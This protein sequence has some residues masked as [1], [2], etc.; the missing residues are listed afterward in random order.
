M[1]RLF[2]LLSVPAF[3]IILSVPALAA[4][5]EDGYAFLAPGE[6]LTATTPLSDV[7]RPA[8]KVADAQGNEVLV[9]AKYAAGVRVFG[10]RTVVVFPRGAKPFAVQA[11][12]QS[13]IAE[14]S[15]A[16]AAKAALSIEDAQ[17]VA[18]RDVRQRGGA[19]ASVPEA[20]LSEPET[21]MYRDA[22]GGLRLCHHLTVPVMEGAVPT[23]RDY[24]IDAQS[25]AVVDAFSQL[26]DIQQRG[27]TATTGTGIGLMSDAVKEFPIAAHEGQYR[28]FDSGR[29]IAISNA[30]L[31][32]YSL[33]ADHVWDRVGTDRPS[34]QRAEVE[35][36]LN[37][38]QIVD[39]YKAHYGY[40]WDGT[41]AAVAHAPNPQTGQPNFNNAYFHPWYNAFFF[42]DGTA[43][44]NGFD[45]LGKALDVAGHEFGHG[46]ISKEGPLV[47]S[48][49]SG[50]LNEHIA[51]LF[52]A[53]IDADDWQMGDTITMGVSAGKGLRNMQDPANGHPELLN[54]GTTFAQ[55]R[56]L[57][58]PRPI[59]DT[60]YPDHVSKKIVCE[61][62]EDNGGVHLNSSIFNKFAYLASSGD[63]L[64]SEGL[65][66]Q[67]LADIYVR[68]MKAD[69]YGEHA[70]FTEFRDALLAAAALELA[71]NPKK[72]VYLATMKAAFGKVGL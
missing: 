43:T 13:A 52:G 2:G 69:L 38:M 55:W 41:V 12:T 16:P 8:K 28:L 31:D 63:G 22:A 34:N 72:D 39:Y 59:G 23:T 17:S 5:F 51:D 32:V 1:S 64:D 26:Y 62:S 21:V 44:E 40:T 9:Y 29:N 46:F 10:E 37:F 54:P 4:S 68:A 18:T 50:A 11:S 47:Y 42:G 65:G 35:L 61:P 45:Y 58:R 71:N 67:L 15:A 48:G 33:D 49:E 36:Y 19:G 56:A 14:L 27:E 20:W 25:G 30:D 53:C 7:L 3:I 66:R 24:F 6:E 60:I 57:N 70:S